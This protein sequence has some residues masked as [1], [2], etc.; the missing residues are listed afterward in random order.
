MKQGRNAGK[1]HYYFCDST[2]IVY[3]IVDFCKYFK[4]ALLLNISVLIPGS[5]RIMQLRHIGCVYVNG[6]FNALC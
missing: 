1:A 4:Q 5:E 6:I 3:G 2:V